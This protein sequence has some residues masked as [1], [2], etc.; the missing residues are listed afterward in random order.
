MTQKTSIRRIEST[1]TGQ[2]GKLS[3]G[4]ETL[5]VPESGVTIDAA[6]SGATLGAGEAEAVP[7]VEPAGAGGDD[8]APGDAAGAE[9]AAAVGA[10]VGAVVGAAVGAVVGVAAGAAVAAGVGAATGVG[11]GGRGATE[12][13]TAGLRETSEPPVPSM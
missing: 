11:E 10:A 4:V 6:D 13:S 9:L 12:G 7:P 2:N 8:A 5:R 3:P 1:S